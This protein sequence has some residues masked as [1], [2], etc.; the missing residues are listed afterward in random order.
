MEYYSA[1]KREKLESFVGE[2]VYLESVIVSE[3]NEI[4][5]LSN[6]W[7]LLYGKPKLYIMNKIRNRK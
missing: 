3:I 6:T 7:F 2:K 5:K 4:H 1:I